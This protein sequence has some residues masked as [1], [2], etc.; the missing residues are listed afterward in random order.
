MTFK[1]K[2]DVINWIILNQLSRRNLTNE[3]KAYFIG[4]LYKN[5][6]QKKELNLKSNLTDCQNLAINTSK[7]IGKEYNISSASVRN[8][9]TFT[10]VIDKI[11]MINPQL[12]ND[13]LA[14]NTNINKTDIIKIGALNDRELKAIL[15]KIEKGYNVSLLL[16]GVERKNLKQKIILEARKKETTDN[17]LIDIFITKKK[18]RIIYIDAPFEYAIDSPLIKSSKDHYPT[19]KIEEIKNL[20]VSNIAEKN[21]VLFFWSPSPLIEKSLDI[22]RHWNFEYKSMFVWDKV[23]HNMGHY[24]SVRHEILIIATKGKCLPDTNKLYGSVVSIERSNHSEK[25]KEFRELIEKMYVAGNKIEL[26]SRTPVENWDRWG[27]EA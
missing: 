26:F 23:K 17:S 25:P 6:K 2:N 18:Y 13:I 1:N 7:K 10:N 20:P 9:E 12:K 22:I 11:G 15:H 16:K 14:G 8:N 27:Y 21:S 24:N 3:A 4:M 19:L 5:T